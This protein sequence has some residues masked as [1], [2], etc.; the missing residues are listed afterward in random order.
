MGLTVL[1]CEDTT[2]PARQVS[3][4]GTTL[5]FFDMLLAELNAAVAEDKPSSSSNENDAM[6]YDHFEYYDEDGDL[7]AVRTDDELESMLSSYGVDAMIPDDSGQDEPIRIRLKSSRVERKFSSQQANSSAQIRPDD[8]QL[9]ERLCD[10]QFGTVYKA[11]DVKND[12]YVAVKSIAIGTTTV[13][14]SRNGLLNEIDILRVAS[15]SPYIVEFYS[16]IFSDNELL[17]CLELMDGLSLDRYGKLPT[18][19]LGGVSVCVVNGLDYLWSR[20]IIHRDIKPSNFLINRKGDVKLADFGV[21]K[22]MAQSVAWSYVGTK[23]YM[24]PERLGGDLYKIHSDVWSLGVSLWE[25]SLGQFP[26]SKFDAMGVVAK[27]GRRGSQQLDKVDD[28]YPNNGVKDFDDLIAGCLKQNPLD[29]LRPQEIIES[30]FI[31]RHTPVNRKTLSEFV[32]QK[33]GTK[34]DYDDTEKN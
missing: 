9:L 29:R 34:S 18:D 11:L 33:L 10:G 21:S 28:E 32:E 3:L 8:L 31:Q 13:G 22:Q 5:M 6:E 19:I 23:V 17:I 14:L 7:I 1:I 12:R 27:F 4:D 30:P 26:F 20:N 2:H 16:A 24:A 25:M 15:K